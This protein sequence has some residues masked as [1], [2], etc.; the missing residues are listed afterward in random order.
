MIEYLYEVNT[1]PLIIIQQIKSSYGVTSF[2]LICIKNII[3]KKKPSTLVQTD[4]TALLS[5][6]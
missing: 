5:F 6:M 3:M 1:V 2:K 4:I